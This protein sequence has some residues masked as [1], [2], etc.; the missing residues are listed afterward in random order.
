MTPIYI[1]I[2]FLFIFCSFCVFLNVRFSKF[3]VYFM[4]CM[5]LMILFTHMYE[6]LIYHTILCIVYLIFSMH[7]ELDLLDT[8]IETI[9]ICIY[10]I[11]WRFCQW[12]LIFLNSI[13]GWI[14]Y[15][16]YTYYK[17]I[18]RVIIKSAI[19]FCLMYLYFNYG[20]EYFII[21]FRLQYWRGVLIWKV[22]Y[23]FYILIHWAT[24]KH[25]YNIIKICILKV[26]LYV[27][28]YIVLHK[29]STLIILVVC[30]FLYIYYKIWSSRK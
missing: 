26:I 21:W 29:I 2:L 14:I 20:L 1:Y 25:Y 19:G 7:K 11:A 22:I 13:I 8:C 27:V 10:D 28:S 16:C 17:F 23:Y 3:I 18:F 24:I 30:L 12:F 6:Y 15:I 5:E 9:I 4:L